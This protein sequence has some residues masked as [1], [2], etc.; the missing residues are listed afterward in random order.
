MNPI[1]LG[2]RQITYL[3]AVAEAGSTAAAARA[4]NVSQPS[5]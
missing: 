4:V 5:V 1:P 3:L 2:L